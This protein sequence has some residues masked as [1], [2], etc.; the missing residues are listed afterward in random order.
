M[1]NDIDTK[2]RYNEL[3][4][5]Y[6]NAEKFMDDD[7]IDIGLR[8]KYIPNLQ[9]LM[10]EMSKTLDIIGSYSNHEI[11]NGFSLNCDSTLRKSS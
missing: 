8:E 1:S 3:I 9:K 5:R 7:T 6:K 2:I 11:L 4:V 10:G